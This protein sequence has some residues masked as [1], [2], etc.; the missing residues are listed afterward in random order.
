MS[1]SQYANK[2]E[3]IAEDLLSIINGNATVKSTAVLLSQVELNMLRS[4]RP[5]KVTESG[6][7]SVFGQR[8][9]WINRA[10]V[11]TWKGEIPILEYK[12]FDD[13]N[14][15]IINKI[16]NQ[17]VEYVQELAIRYLRPPSPPLPGDII[18]KQEPDY[19]PQTAPPLIIRQQPNRPYT[20]EP[21][22]VREAPPKLSNP[23]GIKRITIPSKK[24]PPPPRRVVIERIPSLPKKPQ[25]VIVERWLPYKETKQKIVLKKE[26]QLKDEFVTPRNIIVNWE[27][28]IATVRRQVKYCGV[29]RA[30]PVKY[31]EKFGPLLLHNTAFPEYV[32]DIETPREYGSLAADQ[33]EKSICQLEG[34]L[35]GFQ[36]VDLDSEGLSEYRP[37]LIEKGIRYLEQS[38]SLMS[39]LSSGISYESN[40]SAVVKAGVEIFK[41]IDTNNV[42]VIMV[43]E[44]IRLV[45]KM[46]SQLKQAYRELEIRDFFESISNGKL[47]IDQNQFLDAFTKLA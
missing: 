26:P 30:D 38:E 34:H 12:L 1:H 3:T 19:T 39:S 43:E 5:I 28:P 33:T 9:I 18:I 4:T 46:N 42:G 2:A 10:E 16:T 36:Y 47:L 17:S 23:I 44:A 22:V 37:Q 32:L 7:V 6:E 21:L 15:Q 24:I 11:E 13:R 40:S 27:S 25:K 29:V 35:E 8:G 20:P 45:L 41:L 14:P 31:V